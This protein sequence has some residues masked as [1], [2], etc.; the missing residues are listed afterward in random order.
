MIGRGV[1]AS[2][3]REFGIPTAGM[4]AISDYLWIVD[5]TTTTGKIVLTATATLIGS[6]FLFRSKPKRKRRAATQTI[7][8]WG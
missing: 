7:S 3:K 4:G 5:P 8:L 6:Y 1:V 2:V